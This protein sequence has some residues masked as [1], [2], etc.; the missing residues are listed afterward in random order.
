MP[1]KS[2]MNKNNLL[3]E[4]FFDSLIDIVRKGKLGYLNNKLDQ[5]EKKYDQYHS[6][7]EKIADTINNQYDEL[8]KLLS[9]KY[10]MKKSESNKLT[11]DSF[12]KK[13]Q[14]EG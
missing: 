13:Q 1:K 7:L 3:S 11:V 9:K 2:Y 14:K 8:D 6:E 5:L 10:G 4:G 12:I